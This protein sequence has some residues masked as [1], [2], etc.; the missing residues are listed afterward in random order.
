MIS[1]EKN[2]HINKP[3]SD[4]FAFMVD[5]ANNAKWQDGI[6]NS[7]KT[8][9]GPMG[10]GSTGTIV[11]KF[12]GKEMKNEISVT[13]FEPGKRFAAKSVAGPVQF[14]LDSTFEAMGDGTHLTATM[15][16]EAA[17]FFKVAEGLL[18]GELEKN[19]DRDFAK[20]KELLEA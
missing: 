14:E 3:P 11:Q 2:I 17:G 15:K 20:L 16:A 4:V 18:K 19:T 12:M 1:I 8:S 5:F 7:E 13:A 9:A 6:I 10:V